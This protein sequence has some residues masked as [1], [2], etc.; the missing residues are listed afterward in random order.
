MARLVAKK[1]KCGRQVCVEFDLHSINRIPKTKF[2]LFLLIVGNER[3][4]FVLTINITHRVIFYTRFA[5][6]KGKANS[7]IVCDAK[8]KMRVF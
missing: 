8:C 7:I 1:L 3:F 4:L 2:S 6:T 5:L